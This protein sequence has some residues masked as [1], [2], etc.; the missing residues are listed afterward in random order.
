MEPESPRDSS[1]QDSQDAPPAPPQDLWSSILDSVSSSRSIPSKNILILGQPSSGKSTV[2]EALLGRTK[3]N[4]NNDNEESKS[5]FAMG[6]DWADVRDD[7]DEDTLARLSVYTVPSSHPSFTSLIPSF[8]PPKSSLGHTTVIVALDW[9][10]P[11]TFVEEMEEWFAWIEQWAGGELSMPMVSAE[12]KTKDLKKEGRELDMIREENRERWQSYLQ[13]YT[14]PS[15]DPSTLVPSTSSTA[16]SSNAVLPLGPGTLTH[17]AAGV[18]IIVVCTKADLID[19]REEG[20]ANI[21]GIGVPTG[22]GGGMVKGKGGEWEERTDGIMQILRTICLKYGAS[23][24]YTTNLPETLS[25]LR[26]YALHTLFVPSAPSLTSLPSSSGAIGFGEAQNFSTVSTNSLAAMANATASTATRNPFPFS[27]RPNTLDRDRVVIPSG[28]DSWGKIAVL[29][30]FEPT[31]WGEG[32]EADLESEGREDVKNGAKKMYRDLVPDLGT[33]PPPLPPFNS[34]IPEQSFLARNYDESTKKADRDPRGAFRNPVEGDGG[35]YGLNSTSGAGTGIVGPMGTNS[36]NL[37]N[38]EKLFMEMEGS[39][40]DRSDKLS[41]SLSDRPDRSDRLSSSL[42]ERPSSGHDRRT[43]PTTNRPTMLTSTGASPPSG[44]G[45]SSP[46]PSSLSPS[47]ISPTSGAQGAGGSGQSQHEVL[48]NFFQS[49]LSSK[50]KKERERGAGS[51]S[52]GRP[53]SGMSNGSSKDKGERDKVDKDE[54]SP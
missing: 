8:L 1:I 16:L 52:M 33:K 25:V 9:T 20:T 41:S 46:S 37:P 2:C 3:V 17:N 35:A 11:W 53:K 4:S 5:D 43:R 39:P 14:E 45:P 28:W 47:G 40:S 42:N 6:Y 27:H 31:V 7:A 32:W 38:V 23:L 36:F 21:G 34:P 22:L 15:S 50:D 54:G 24:F 18:P 19:E 49:L 51:P 10:K 48:Q 13:H 44:K 30:E 29:R 26:Q 12:V